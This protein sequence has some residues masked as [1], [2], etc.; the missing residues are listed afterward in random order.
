MMEIAVVSS[1]GDVENET[2]IVNNMLEQGLKF[3][4]LRKP[5]YDRGRMAKYLDDIKTGYYSRIVLHSHY[6]L[7]KEHDLGGIHITGSAAA[8]KESIIDSVR[9]GN[10]TNVRIGISFHDPNELYQDIKGIDYTFL[11]P[12]FDS[13]S[14]KGYTK[15]FNHEELKEVLKNTGYKVFA[16]GGCRK[17]NM[18]QIHK[19]GFY[20][21]AFLGAVWN[22]PNPLGSYQEIKRNAE[23]FV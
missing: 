21:A 10:E 22:S 14:K 16:L 3:F 4:H 6:D 23:R 20:G 9:K 18:G 8:K 7:L 2:I 11:S 17:E 1:P 19:M 15:K 5:E 13:I 12:V